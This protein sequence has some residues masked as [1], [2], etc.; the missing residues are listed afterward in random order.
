MTTT[1][2]V[3]NPGHPNPKGDHMPTTKIRE[4]RFYV[5]CDEHT[6]GPFTTVEAAERRR[7]EIV[8]LGEC[9]GVHT[10]VWP[11]DMHHSHSL[12]NIAAYGVVRATIADG[13]VYLHE[14]ARVDGATNYGHALEI[15][16]EDGPMTRVDFIYACDCWEAR[17]FAEPRVIW[18]N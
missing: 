4:D 14:V 9:G 8:S 5:T 2:R 17:S 11:Y 6:V 15:A 7:D 3:T 12:D 13:Q 1:G 18:T 10:I 16:R